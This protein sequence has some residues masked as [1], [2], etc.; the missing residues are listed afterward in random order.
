[1]VYQIESMETLCDKLEAKLC[2]KKGIKY[3]KKSKDK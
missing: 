2:K 3:I 1:M